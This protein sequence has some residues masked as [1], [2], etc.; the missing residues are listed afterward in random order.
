LNKKYLMFA[1]I[2]EMAVVCMPH[3]SRSDKIRGDGASAPK[4]LKP[5][6]LITNG[7]SFWQSIHHTDGYPYA[8]RRASAPLGLMLKK[9]R[10]GCQKGSKGKVTPMILIQVDCYLT[11]PLPMPFSIFLAITSPCVCGAPLIK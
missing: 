10:K 5:F 7:H 3:L 11:F 4:G 8:M 2:H 9:G 6:H 1:L